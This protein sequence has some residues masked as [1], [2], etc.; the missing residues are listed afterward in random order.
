M[1]RCR[2]RSGHVWRG[3]GECRRRATERIVGISGVEGAET[4]GMPPVRF[5][6][7]DPR[8]AP[9]VRAIR[10]RQRQHDLQAK[11]DQIGEAGA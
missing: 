11:G 7:L 9:W 5:K 4:G 1:R 2:V 6:G 10:V 8:F 3:F